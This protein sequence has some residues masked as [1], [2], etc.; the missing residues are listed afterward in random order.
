M[1]LRIALTGS[2]R[3]PPLY[4]VIQVLGEQEVRQ[5]LGLAIKACREQVAGSAVS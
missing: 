2:D 3:T 4:E 5:R 1:T